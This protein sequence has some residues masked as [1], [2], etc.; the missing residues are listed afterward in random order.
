MT[1]PQIV[2]AKLSLTEPQRRFAIALV[3]HD[4]DIRYAARQAGV[5]DPDE[6]LRIPMMQ[7][8]LEY[9]KS[10]LIE[11]QDSEETG[12]RERIACRED[13]G[14]FL[15]EVLFDSAYSVK[16]KMQAVKIFLTDYKPES[17]E[18]RQVLTVQ[19]I[20]KQMEGVG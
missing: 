17:A 19:E 5:S 6:M 2:T 15:S 18:R 13:A 4:G 3:A 9:L 14:R 7:T 11:I 16:E 10:R 8:Y 12:L 1:T 20:E